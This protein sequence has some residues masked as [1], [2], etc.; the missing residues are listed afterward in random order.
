MH[1]AITAPPPKPTPLNITLQ[2]WS[3]PLADGAVC[4]VALNR[5][6]KAARLNISWEMIG[7][8]PSAKVDL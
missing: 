5:G 2:V 8:Q 4:V 3:K 7:L 1:A 6:E